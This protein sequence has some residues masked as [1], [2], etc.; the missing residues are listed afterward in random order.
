MQ[1]RKMQRKTYMQRKILI[2]KCNFAK[3]NVVMDGEQREKKENT[4]R[5]IRNHEN[6]KE[7]HIGRE[8]C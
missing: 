5:T 6:S 7:K 8:G 2:R 1:C 3:R 4:G